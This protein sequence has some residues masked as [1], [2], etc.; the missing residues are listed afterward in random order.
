MK[1]ITTT[2]LVLL[3]SS[4]QVYAQNI[5]IE[6]DAEIHESVKM[7]TAVLLAQYINE[8]GY[9]CRSISA[10]TPFAFKRGFSVMCNNWQYHFEV[11]DRG[12]KYIITV[13]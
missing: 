2:L 13:K 3:A 10:V 6:D 8:K 9:S 4:F 11:E 5:T 7:E 12:G 1:V